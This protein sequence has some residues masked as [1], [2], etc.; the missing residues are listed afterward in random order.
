MKICKKL[1]QKMWNVK[2]NNEIDDF[3]WSPKGTSLKSGPRAAWDNAISA[4]PY[5]LDGYNKFFDLA[6]TDINLML[7]TKVSNFDILSKKDDIW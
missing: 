2:N 5:A 1:F 6:V 4:Y 7:N 3:G